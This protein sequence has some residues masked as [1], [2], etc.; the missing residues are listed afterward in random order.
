VPDRALIIGLVLLAALLHATWNAVTQRSRDPLLAIWLVSVAS[1]LCLLVLAP[2]AS[3]PHREAWPWLGGSLVLHLAYQLSLVSAYRSGDLSHVYPIARGLGPCVVALFAALFGGE[4]L[5]PIQV[6]GLAL[7][8]L[9]VASLA[10]AGGALRRPLGGA[11]R[12]ALLTGVMI[13]SYT[14]VDAQGVRACENPLDFIVWSMVLDSLPITAVA[15][16]ARRGRVMAYLR[17]DLRAGVGGG[18]MAALAYGIVLWAMSTSPMAS[19]A[20][21]R[22]TS[23]IFA[24]WIG[25]RL[26]GEPFGSRRLLAACGV[27]AG[28][29]LLQIQK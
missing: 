17:T 24:A 18:C 16:W 15:L 11:V 10:V 3:F 6:A 19:I 27:A 1:G 22:E 2:F 29:A 20:A 13:G 14:F 21:L 26:F 28:V 7:A 8:S 23:V 12:A 25:T 4:L 9:S 5:T